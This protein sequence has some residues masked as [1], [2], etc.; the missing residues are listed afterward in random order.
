MK[1]SFAGKIREAAKIL[2]AQ[3][4]RFSTEDLSHAASIQTYKDRARMRQ[5]MRDLVRAGEAKRVEPGVYVYVGK[6]DQKPQKQVVML[7]LLKMRRTVSVEDLQELAGVSADYADEWLQMLARREVVRA[8][9][10]GNYTL[11]KEPEEM[12]RNDEKAERL[13]GIRLRKKVNALKELGKIKDALRRA[14]AAIE[15]LDL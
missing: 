1:E 12:P 6:P 7:E 8:Q 3:G 9:G 5:T 2:G 14:E 10:N 11:I 15:D 13:R 4:K